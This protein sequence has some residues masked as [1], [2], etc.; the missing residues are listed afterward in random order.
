MKKFQG[1]ANV[2]VCGFICVL[3]GIIYKKLK[4]IHEEIVY[5][6]DQKGLLSKKQWD[7]VLN[8]SPRNEL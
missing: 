4:D 8:Y 3:G 1:I 5:F 2:A 6:E 7:R